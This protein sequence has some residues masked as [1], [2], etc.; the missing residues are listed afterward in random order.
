MRILTAKP[1]RKSKPVYSSHPAKRPDTTGPGPH[2]TQAAQLKAVIDASNE[3]KV[4]AGLQRTIGDTPRMAFQRLQIGSI[5]HEAA[6]KN[7]NTA[8]LPEGLQAGIENLSGLSMEDVRVHHNSPSPARWQAQAYTQGR[9]IYLAPGQERHLPH[10][11]WHVVQQARGGVPAMARSSKAAINYD[12]VLEHQA[13]VMGARAARETR[14]GPIAASARVARAIPA[15][16]PTNT[17]Q[18]NG[19]TLAEFHK[20][21]LKECPSGLCDALTAVWLG[22]LIHPNTEDDTIGVEEENFGKIM[23]LK[24]L[25]FQTGFNSELLTFTFAQFLA[26]KEKGQHGSAKAWFDE[27]SQETF[28][29]KTQEL[30]DYVNNHGQAINQTITDHTF[31]TGPVMYSSIK[32]QKLKL[33]LWIKDRLEQYLLSGGGFHGLVIINAYGGN[34]YGQLDMAPSANHQFAFRYKA[35]FRQFQ[36]MDQNKGLVNLNYKNPT[37]LAIDLANYIYRTY[38]EHPMKYEGVKPSSTTIDFLK[39]TNF[40]NLTEPDDMEKLINENYV[41]PSNEETVVKDTMGAEIR[42]RLRRDN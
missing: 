32:K 9:N 29:T 26:E 36:I 28:E 30:R 2:G 17:M 35:F 19:W 25:F 41:P 37:E 10:E 1:A 8:G 27:L 4:L 38:V 33:I 18:F 12:T 21:L 22:K 6:Q 20:K 39:N 14:G 7:G 23:L 42:M 3:R 13:D 15:A 5:D 24:E 16:M 31:G 40:N 11:A 34:E